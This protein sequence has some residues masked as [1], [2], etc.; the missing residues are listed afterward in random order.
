MAIRWDRPGQTPP[1]SK[2]RF[3]GAIYRPRIAIFLGGLVAIAFSFSGAVGPGMADIV[4]NIAN[5]ALS[6]TFFP[7]AR[8]YKS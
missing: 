7:G 4:V 1:K 8:L 5:C 3:T 2:A 6:Q